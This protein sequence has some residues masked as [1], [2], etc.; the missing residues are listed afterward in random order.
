MNT[1]ERILQE[2][3]LDSEQSILMGQ[4]E[5]DKKN[6][7]NAL[8][9]VAIVFPHFSLHDET[10][11]LTILNNIVKMLGE[12]VIRQLSCTDLWCEYTP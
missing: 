9:A 3:S 8:K 1:V 6:I 5:F 12:S 2:K 7:P 4:W 10:H 11:S